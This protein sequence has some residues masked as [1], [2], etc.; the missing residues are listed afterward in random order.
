MF[1]KYEKT[2]GVIEYKRSTCYPRQDWFI[3]FLK[4]NMFG[5]MYVCIRILNFWENTE[6]I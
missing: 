5:Y 3:S 1:A 6:W 2:P 4:R